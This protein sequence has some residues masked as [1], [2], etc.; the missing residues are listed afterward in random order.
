MYCLAGRYSEHYVPRLERRF[1]KDSDRGNWGSALHSGSP[2]V[3]RSC[4]NRYLSS[5]PTQ[6]I[7]ILNKIID[8]YLQE[9]TTIN[10]KLYII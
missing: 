4:C 3:G 7:Y 8:F 5:L 6:G 10:L 1:D 2:S 9:Y